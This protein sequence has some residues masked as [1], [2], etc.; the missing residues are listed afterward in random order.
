MVG[1]KEPHLRVCTNR[2]T[3]A[4]AAAACGRQGGL[5]VFRTKRFKKQVKPPV[6]SVK[7]LGNKRFGAGDEIRHR[8]HQ[9][10]GPRSMF[11]ESDAPR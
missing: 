7:K 10:S 1:V 9:G 4:A 5:S 11:P 8:H 2:S 3:F 6:K